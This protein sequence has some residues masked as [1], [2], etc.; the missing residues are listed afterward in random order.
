DR[1]SSVMLVGHNPGME[2]LVR[3]LTNRIEP[4]PT[5]AVAIIDL[6]IEHWKDLAPGTGVLRA[7]FR[8]RDEMGEKKDD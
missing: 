5:A 6:P 3:V 1:F 7:V 2:G 4:M 8:P